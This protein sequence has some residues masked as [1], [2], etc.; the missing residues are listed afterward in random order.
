MR[1]LPEPEDDFDRTLVAN[2]RRYGWG[3]IDVDPA[4]HP[5]HGDGDAPPGAATFA[6]T[7]GVWR[8]YAHPEIILMGGWRHAHEL[9]ANVVSLIE[10]GRSF[11]PGEATGDV[12]DG[13][14]VRFGAVSDAR[15]RG[16]PHVRLV[17]QRPGAVRG[18]AAHP[19]RRRRPVAVA[20]RLRR[21]P[22]AAARL[23]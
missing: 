11:R 21:V 2:I 5:E 16:G 3:Y 10:A 14:P 22:A 15:R 17:G 20:A 23:S 1:D 13:A 18:A 7:A 6:Y 19:A 8:T 4:N 12:L 9:V